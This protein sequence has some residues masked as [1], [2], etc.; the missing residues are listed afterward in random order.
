M[1]T[2]SHHRCITCSAARSLSCKDALWFCLLFLLS[3]PL[4]AD[5]KF[6]LVGSNAS[7][8]AFSHGYHTDEVGMKCAECHVVDASVSGH[9]N[10]LPEWSVCAAC[11]EQ[12]DL[13]GKGIRLKGETEGFAT[14]RI[15]EYLPKFNHERHVKKVGLD[16]AICHVG[17]DDA[18]SAL[19][20]AP[21]PDMATCVNC[22]TERVVTTECNV[23]HMPEDKLKP[24][25]HNV[26]WIQQHGI[27]SNISSANCAMCH[28]SGSERDCQS[29][30]NGDA[31]ISPHPHEYLS[32]HGH[33]AHL[34]DMRCGV[35]HEQRSFCTDCHRDMGILPA[36]HF[37]AG[38]VTSDGGTHGMSAEFDLESCMS[39]HDVPNQEPV[40]ARCHDAK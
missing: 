30:H 20:K 15:A 21:L 33:D 11:H 7:K 13:S 40:C 31:V 38:F 16:C 2:T 19:S 6:A 35:C 36:D 22:H 17:L 26:M 34:S 24:A 5:E 1:K 4:L 29:C 23:C 27:A 25:D 28:Q 37:R 32:T 12:N 3:V 9:D 14:I 39:C 18:R 8:P 10:L